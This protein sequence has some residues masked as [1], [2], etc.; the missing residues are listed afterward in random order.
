TEDRIIHEG[1]G[2]TLKGLKTDL[3]TPLQ[4]HFP[5]VTLR[6]LSVAGVTD[7][8]NDDDHRKVAEV[9][10]R[11]VLQAEEWRGRRPGRSV[12]AALSGGRK[13]M[14]AVLQKAAGLF[15]VD[16]VYHMV[17]ADE[18]RPINDLETIRQQRS[19]HYPICMSHTP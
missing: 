1:N 12:S 8:A 6:V 14:S 9:L 19:I 15:D 3:L 17:L 5:D 13:T 10:Y 7:I 4:T 18:S 11:L 16:R 2:K